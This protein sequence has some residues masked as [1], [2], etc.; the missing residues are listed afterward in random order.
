MSSGSSSS[1]DD[2]PPALVSEYSSDDG[3]SD[4]RLPPPSS[5]RT[6]RHRLDYGKLYFG[7][8]LNEAT[9]DAYREADHFWDIPTTRQCASVRREEGESEIPPNRPTI[10][11]Q[12]TVQDD[13]S[14]F[15]SRSAGLK[16]EKHSWDMSGPQSD[17]PEGPP[18][19]KE[20][21]K[22]S[23][24]APGFDLGPGK[25]EKTGPPGSG[26]RSSHEGA[27]E[28]GPGL[29]GTEPAGEEY[30]ETGAQFGQGLVMDAQHAVDE[31][32]RHCTTFMPGKSPG[33][34]QKIEEALHDIILEL[35]QSQLPQEGATPTFSDLVQMTLPVLCP[36]GELPIPWPI[37][38]TGPS[39]GTLGQ[40]AGSAD[41]LQRA[42][43]EPGGLGAEGDVQISSDSDSAL[44]LLLYSGS[45]YGSSD[46]ERSSQR[47]KRLGGHHKVKRK[48]P[49]KEYLADFAIMNRF[50]GRGRG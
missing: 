5:P 18:G 24:G 39:Q 50:L 23:G 6:I 42:Q 34:R 36:P 44:S 32:L 8:Y 25:R 2:G 48:K 40:S 33:E 9:H 17:D 22:G 4:D 41:G 15:G 27:L 3:P 10:S 35:Q 26:A 46:Q 49:H 14:Y 11:R 19:G 1:D 38:N 13:H 45:I 28:T 29:E 47:K 30:Q 37:F 20:D 16:P 43:G 12:A 31:I 21:R 7:A